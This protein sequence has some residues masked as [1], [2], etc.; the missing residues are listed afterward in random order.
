MMQ[1]GVFEHVSAMAAVVQQIYIFLSNERLIDV[2][3]VRRIARAATQEDARLGRVT[4]IQI[5]QFSRSTRTSVPTTSL[6][7]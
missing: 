7:D 5:I 1:D 2:A 3:I 4:L 6:P